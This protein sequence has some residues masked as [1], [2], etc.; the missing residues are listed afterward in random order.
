MLED[1]HMIDIRKSANDRWN[2]G[3]IY[4][5]RKLKY[6]KRQQQPTH[7]TKASLLLMIK[8]FNLHSKMYI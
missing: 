6:C 2:N 5:I 3:W 4:E 7:Y 1:I 8:S